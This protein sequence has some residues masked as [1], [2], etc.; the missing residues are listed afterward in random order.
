MSVI[1]DRSALASRGV[2]DGMSWPKDK[3]GRVITL[4]HQSFAKDADI[5]NIMA[6]YAVTGVLVDPSNVDAGRQPRFGDFSDLVDYPTMVSR[7]NQAEAD[8]MTLPS[9]VRAKFSNSV[10]EC[11][12]F[13]A[14]PE[15]VVES[16]KL[17]LLPES[18]LEATFAVRPDLRPVSEPLKKEVVPPAPPA[19]VI[20]PD[21]LPP[22][23]K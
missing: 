16:V 12:N 8:F 21:S 6:K 1:C 20:P 13:I 11:L 17:G 7:I 10:E 9:A 3:N 14:Q 15:N 2:D 4:T 18:S 5:N 22:A 23:G 19:A